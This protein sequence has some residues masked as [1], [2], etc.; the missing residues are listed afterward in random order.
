VSAALNFRKC[1]RTFAP[2]L[3]LSCVLSICHLSSGTADYH[4]IFA[5]PP[6]AVSYRDALAWFGLDDAQARARH[7]VVF[8]PSEGTERRKQFLHLMRHFPLDAAFAHD[9]IVYIDR[10]DWWGAALFAN[11]HYAALLGELGSARGFRLLFQYLFQPKQWRGVPPAHAAD[12][13][14]LFQVR[15]QWERTTA[16]ASAFAKCAAQHGLA[17]RHGRM[18]GTQFVLSDTAA[19][20][21]ELRR[22]GRGGSG[23][24]VQLLS[25]VPPLGR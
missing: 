19:D 21:D 14:F 20:V 8:A 25:Q 10:Y 2:I 17:D 23:S 22:L 24:S 1:E 9:Q 12:C 3:T 7:G 11:P 15:R 4:D 13:N 5:A 16:P 6:L 18:T